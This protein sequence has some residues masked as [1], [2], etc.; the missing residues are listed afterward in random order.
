MNT[1]IANRADAISNA[2]HSGCGASCAEVDAISQAI[3]IESVQGA[4]GWAA[5]IG[6]E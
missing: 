5:Q 4:V 3:E 2:I 1:D 6:I